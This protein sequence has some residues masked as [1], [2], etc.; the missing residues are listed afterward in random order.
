MAQASKSKYRKIDPKIW[1]DEKFYTASLSCQHLFL[2]ILT[3]PHMTPVGAMRTSPAGLADELDWS[4]KGFPQAFPEAFAEGCSKGFWKYDKRA[5]FLMVPNFLKY[6]RP[7]SPN[8]I[9]S[10]F[11]CWNDLPECPLKTEVYQ[12]LKGLA[13]GFGEGFA[14]AFTEAFPKDLPED[15]PESGAGAGTVVKS[16]VSSLRSDT[17]DPVKEMF[18]LGVQILGAT[19]MTEPKA[20][21]MIGKVRKLL[22]DEEGLIAVRMAKDKT[23]PVSYLAACCEK[24]FLPEDA[25]ELGQIIDTLGIEDECETIPRAQARIREHLRDHPDDR[26]K[27]ADF[28]EHGRKLA[29]G[30]R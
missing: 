13:K 1:N 4:E 15:M 19:G 9:K 20:R 6:N 18:D 29:S 5:K 2:F 12:L 22:G 23:D 27:I 7:E 8:V 17:A 24:L 21:R 10:W 30:N 14:K 3:H 16:T 11:G 25:I 28:L 26:E